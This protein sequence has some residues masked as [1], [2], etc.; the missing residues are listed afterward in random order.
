MKK[1]SKKEGG[2]GGGGV[3]PVQH[4]TC[5]C[6]GDCQDIVCS[7]CFRLRAH[8]LNWPQ[9]GFCQACL[10]VLLSCTDTPGAFRSSPKEQ[11]IFSA[12]VACDGDGLTESRGDDTSYSCTTH[13]THQAIRA[14][15]DNATYLL[16]PHTQCC[17]LVV[18]S[19][20]LRLSLKCSFSDWSIHPGLLF[21]CGVLENT[22]LCWKATK[23]FGW[24]KC[25]YVQFLRK[26]CLFGCWSASPSPSAVHEDC[27]PV[28]I[29]S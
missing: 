21:E 11:R 23:C 5:K 18:L 17:T 24:E 12:R 22:S 14:D 3:S 29:L 4:R 16:L 25:K 27:T 1:W 7:R 28:R 15:C 8:W 10:L 26:E 20:K 9:G 13:I 19:L 6:G 2:G